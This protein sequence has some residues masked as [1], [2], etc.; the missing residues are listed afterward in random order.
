MHEGKAFYL[1]SLDL[2]FK[3]SGSGLKVENLLKL[4]VKCE[5]LT[6]KI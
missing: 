2:C 4:K 1:D 6:L 3:N 5:K